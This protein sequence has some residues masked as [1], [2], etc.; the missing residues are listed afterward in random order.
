MKKRQ[1]KLLDP[2]DLNIKKKFFVYT[3]TYA[4]KANEWVVG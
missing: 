4:E 2:S 1:I 3:S